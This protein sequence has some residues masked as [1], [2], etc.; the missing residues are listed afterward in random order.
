MNRQA[1]CAE[2]PGTG[3]GPAPVLAMPVGRVAQK[4]PE[5]GD[6]DMG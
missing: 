2:P 1:A 6:K 3:H 5:G 4:R